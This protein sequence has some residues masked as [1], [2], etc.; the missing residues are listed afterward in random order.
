MN[1]D[2]TKEEKELLEEVI[3]F[4]KKESTPEMLKETDDMGD[5]YGGPE[6]RKII[7]KMAAKGWLTPTWPKEY[8]GIDASE[9]VSY[10]IREEMGYQGLPFGFIAAH[11]AGPTILRFGSD[12]MKKKWLPPIARGEYEFALGYTE[13]QAGSDLSALMMKVEDKGDHLLLNGNKIFNTSCHLADYH[14]LAAR[15]NPE[16]PRHKGVSMMIVDLK[17]PGIT[18]SPMI[19]MA[20]WQT[21]EVVYEDV[22]VPKENV[23][24]EVNKGF[25][26][27][28]AALDFERMFPL[29]R[30]R[31]LF[32]N[33][34]D[35]TK[36]TIVNGKPLS[37]D[38]IIRQKMAQ[39]AT[40]I[41]VTRLLYYQLADILDRGGIPN[42]QS[43]MEK[44]FAT[45]TAQRITNIGMD[46]LGLY[47][48]LNEGSKWA[49]LAGK[50]ERSYRTSI[51]ETIYAG[52]S[53]IQRNIIAQRG[54]GLPR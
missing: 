30:Y 11:M 7:Q 8:G 15:T 28:M 40:E 36:E 21:N 37:K 49:K 33:L 18:I 53:E 22:K 25:Y 2:F 39:L 46:I 23:V 29:G 24:G 50:M 10:M 35:Y 13:P 6:G 44:T 12:E 9:V 27:L 41:E 32:D 51:V 42:Y 3:T 54:L 43:S 38:P 34:I 48:Q 47:G 26:Y 14:W 45:E 20:G 52:T 1:F 31:R 17:T 19:T 16:G 4:I 5:I